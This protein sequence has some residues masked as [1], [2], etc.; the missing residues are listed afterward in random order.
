GR[1]STGKRHYFNETFHGKKRAAQD[2]LRVLLTK[3]ATGEPLRLG[4][5]TLAVFIK[6]W[7]KSHPDLKKSSL[8]HYERTL[9]YYVVP[10]LGKL[11]LSKIEANDIQKLYAGLLEDGLDPSTA[12]YVHGRLKSVFKLALLHRNI[13][14]NPMEGVKSPGGKKLRQEKRAARAGRTLSAT[15]VEQF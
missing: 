3:Q 11:M 12:H 1:D 9:D 13:P 6:E 14:F 5:E 4:N 2:R 7:L 15:Q 8:D 10:R